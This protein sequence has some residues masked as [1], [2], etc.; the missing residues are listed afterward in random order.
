MKS[1]MHDQCSFLFLGAE[2]HH[3]RSAVP[4]RSTRALPGPFYHCS[5]HLLLKENLDNAVLVARLLIRV[6]F[7][8]SWILSLL[9]CTQWTF[10][11]LQCG[12]VRGFSSRSTTWILASFSSCIV[13]WVSYA[14]ARCGPEDL[15]AFWIV[16]VDTGYKHPAETLF[17][18]KTVVDNGAWIWQLFTLWHGFLVVVR[19]VR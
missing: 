17:P 14:S 2:V 10:G 19:K 1:G 3:H 13:C 7:P 8:F 9:H 12:C 18:V 11:G 15:S 6:D 4:V 16:L 5:R